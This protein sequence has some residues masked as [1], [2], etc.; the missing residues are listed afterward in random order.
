[1]SRAT[2][3][4]AIAALLLPAFAGGAQSSRPD[5]TDAFRARIASSRAAGDSAA[6]GEALESLGLAHWRADRFDSA[7]VY[8][9]ASRDVSAALRDSTGLGRLA[10]AIGSTHYQAGNYELALES[11]VRALELRAAEGNILGQSYIYSNMG[12]AY[13]DW[14]QYDRA[15]GTLDS[16]ISLAER[17]GD[18]HALGYA[19][20][21]RSSVLVQMRR[22]PEARN[23]AERS[24]AAYFSGRPTL[25]AVDSSSAWS[26]NTMLLGRIDLAEGR[27]ADA[28]RRFKGIYQ[29]A[30][31]GNTRRGQAQA[32]LA[33]GELYEVRGDFRAAA[34]AF[35]LAVTAAEAIG[36]RAQL[37]DALAGLSRAEE[38]RGN[39][40]I[41]LR[42]A[43]RHE[44]L[45]DSI[46][47]A[48]TAQRVATMELEA[49]AARERAAAAAMA[50]SQSDDLRRQRTITVLVSAL[51]TLA[52][53]L[54]VTL[55]RYNARARDREALLAAR[56]LELKS[57]LAEVRTLAGFIPICASCKNV[58]DDAGY[59]QSVEAYIASRSAAQFSHSICN[60]C[61]PKLYGSDW[62]PHPT[63]SARAVKTDAKKV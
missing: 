54:V 4:I 1:M 24:L 55:L 61:G 62:E 17:V 38:G 16:A 41:A 31:R 34:N 8:L 2:L 14:R 35:Q 60:S 20:N 44:A 15:L 59:W 6:L 53:L 33:L 50:Q 5:S 12:K 30:L 58:R 29:V 25:D 56:N 42:V 23:Y 37:L 51:L 48:R 7:L 45:R 18:G 57:A 49:E 36:S 52:L 26:I 28:E 32:Q 19:L 11:Y 27:A 3:S 40:A 39:A 43:R 13:E 22:Y 21:T 10:N 47:N 63:P 46:F 9:S